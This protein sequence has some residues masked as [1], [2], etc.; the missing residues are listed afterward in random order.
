MWYLFEYAG[1]P[2]AYAN[3]STEVFTRL[4]KAI[5]SLTFKRRMAAYSSTLF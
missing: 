4:Q 2:M 1:I 3:S 5:H